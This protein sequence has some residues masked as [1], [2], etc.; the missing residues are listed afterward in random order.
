MDI[1]Q[2]VTY[3]CCA[4]LVGLCAWLTRHALDRRAHVDSGQIVSQEVFTARIQGLE[5]RLGGRI[6]AVNVKLEDL[7]KFT[8]HIDRRLERLID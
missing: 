8:Q 7:E 4:L 2:V 6:A 1:E 3:L 5:D